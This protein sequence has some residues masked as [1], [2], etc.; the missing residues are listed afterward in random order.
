MKQGTSRKWETF[1]QC[2]FAV[3]EKMNH[4]NGFLWWI[5]GRKH[6]QLIPFTQ[7]FKI[8]L[9]KSHRVCNPPRFPLLISINYV[10]WPKADALKAVHNELLQTQTC[11]ITSKTITD[12][13][14][15]S[16]VTRIVNRK[17]RISEQSPT[18]EIQ[19]CPLHYHL[20]SPINHSI[21]APVFIWSCIALSCS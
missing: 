21:Q 5:G 1:L 8:T 18:L 2:N 10:E 9:L 14:P 16:V 11:H 20:I 19:L 15:A 6:S 7:R 3:E 12:S 13:H 4:I 17:I